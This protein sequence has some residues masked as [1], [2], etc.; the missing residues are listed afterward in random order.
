M[1]RTWRDKIHDGQFYVYTYANQDGE[2]AIGAN[3]VQ[4]ILQTLVL[5]K[6]RYVQ[7]FTKGLTESQLKLNQAKRL[8]DT[9]WEILKSMA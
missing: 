1:N 5:S 9:E 2:K 7:D 8:Q 4:V 6:F 3:N